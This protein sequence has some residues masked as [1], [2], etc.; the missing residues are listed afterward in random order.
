MSP[1]TELASGIAMH[2]AGLKPLYLDRVSVPDAAIKHERQLLSE[3]A[4]G[5]GKSQNVAS[6]VRQAHV[7]MPKENWGDC[8]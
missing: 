6:K 4:A 7:D 1:A 8:S 2:A 3:Q 5:S